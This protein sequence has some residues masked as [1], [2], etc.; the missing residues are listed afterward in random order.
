MLQ[1]RPIPSERELGLPLYDLS[2]QKSRQKSCFIDS[3]RVD[4]VKP[5]TKDME[6]KNGTAIK[7]LDRDKAKP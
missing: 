5:T 4:T 3:N 2:E 1:L 6:N 7:H